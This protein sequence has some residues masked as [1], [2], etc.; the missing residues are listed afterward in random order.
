MSE[1]DQ[2]YRIAF[3]SNPN[4][5]CFFEQDT[6]LFFEVNQAASTY[7]GYSKDE[8]LQLTISNVDYSIDLPTLH[9]FNQRL[10]NQ[11]H[12]IEECQHYKKDGSV[13]DVE[14]TISGF[15]VADKRV[16][17]MVIKDITTL[18]RL[19]AER[20]ETEAL[21][22]KS[23]K[24][25]RFALDLTGS[26]ARDWNLA[27]GEVV[28]SDNIF[29]ILGLVNCTICKIAMFDRNMHYIA[30]NQSWVDT[31]QLGSIEAILGHSHYELFPNL[32]ER[33]RQ[34][35]QQALLGTTIISHEDAF[36]LADGSIQWAKWEVQP[37]FLNTGEVGGIV[38]FLE[39]I[40]ERKQAEIALRESQQ[41][42]KTVLNSFPLAIF[43]KDSQ[44]IFQGCN[45]KFAS[46]SGLNSPSEVIGK[47]VFDF[48]CNELQAQGYL[49]DD[50]QVIE[51]G[52]AKL[53]IEETITL[54]TGEQIWVETNKVP[55]RDVNGNV[56][57]LIC[58]F[59]DITRRKL[60]EDE[61]NRLFSFLDSSL[62]EIYLLD[63]ETLQFIYVNQGAIKNLGYDSE[64]LKNMTVLHLNPNFN[65][66]KFRQRIQP[67]LED[68]VQKHIFES[69]HRRADGS[70][71]RVEIHLQKH[72]Y[73]NKLF[74]L[75][76]VIDITT[77]IQIENELEQQRKDL[78]KLAAIVTSSQ[79]AIISKNTDGII[80]NWNRSAEE[81]F[82]YS[83]REIIGQHIFTLIPFELQYQ[84]ESLL[85]KIKKG[86]HIN[87]YETQ[88]QRKDGRIINVELTI[89][90]I[91]GEIE[92]NVIGIS[93]IARDI[94]ERK[95]AEEQLQKT[96][97]ELS[98]ATRL[99][100]EFL[101]NMSHELRTPLNAILGMTEVLQEE[102]FGS[103]NIQQV[104]ALQT[105]EKSGS[106]LLSLINDILDLAK[107]ESGQ[108]ELEC[109]EVSIIPICSSSITLIKQ[110]A[111]KKNIQLKTTIPPNLP[112]LL[113]DERRIRQVLINLLNNAVKF[114]PEG[115]KVT[116]EV[117]LWSQKKDSLQENY[118]RI[119]VTDTGIG[120]SAQD[121]NKLFK[122]FVQIDSAL[123]RQ[124]QGIGLGLALVKQ[125]IELHKGKVEVTSEL[126]VG[127]CFTIYLPF[128][129]SNYLWSESK[130]STITALD[131]E[132]FKINPGGSSY[133]LL[134]AE[135][136]E[137]NIKTF[138]AYL[139]A[140]GYRL[141]VAK[142]GQ[143][144][145]NLA[146]SQCPDLILMDIQ[147]PGISGLEAIRE[148]RST[149]NLVTTP[150][151]ALTALAMEGD[152]ELCLEAGANEYLAKPVKLKQLRTLIQSLLS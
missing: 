54:P 45:E 126:G 115:G 48:P 47:T 7:Y 38:I 36:I 8:F 140:M 12:H 41:F 43:W 59:Q 1:Y 131:E 79:D 123:N 99:K 143:E 61:R 29:N 27:T 105:I 53:G 88:R 18:K 146:F 77:R 136:N 98:R 70:Y 82:G 19:E 106:H 114:T 63:G 95:E 67:L 135:D 128:Q 2:I 3:E 4:P 73:Q 108:E 15:V 32:P 103:L 68:K 148:I 118:L 42:V 101:A 52:Q 13:T 113:V 121:I 102:I 40:T 87:T 138:K 37:W 107:I 85:Q 145:I 122:P 120:I 60:A 46:V 6:G 25:Y 57:A 149:L 28:W 111:L 34:V 83:A 22:R 69:Q 39:D 84:E 80:L 50:R 35:Y 86:Q 96:N 51:S 78:A 58:T 33:L 14:V 90:P 97:I 10:T 24:Q 130:T 112:N 152:R 109:T 133:L 55:L 56:I 16:N 66:R 119:A 132:N 64:T 100:D 124:Y 75:A 21:L 151:I 26:A 65:E 104:D 116:L 94:S 20:Q 125:I 139:E 11:Q 110:L 81:L 89:S 71:Y 9:Q 93:V 17:L 117:S 134:L 76:V 74:F 72:L 144:A 129:E 91:L 147:M 49:A 142:N 23:E 150:I 31:Y 44:S 92:N 62:N 30:V 127:S 141:I 137:S 5:M